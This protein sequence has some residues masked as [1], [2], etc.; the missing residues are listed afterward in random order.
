MCGTK[1]VIEHSKLGNEAEVIECLG[2]GLGLLNQPQM[3]G[4]KSSYSHFKEPVHYITSGTKHRD[5]F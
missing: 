1:V 4:A 2:A 3:R 5:C